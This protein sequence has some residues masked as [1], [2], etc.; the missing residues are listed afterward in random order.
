V[1]L[2]PEPAGGRCR[3]EGCEREEAQYLISVR[4]VR[5]DGGFEA[6]S[7]RRHV[8]LVA[9]ALAEEQRAWVKK[10]VELSEMGELD[11]RRAA[12]LYEAEALP[13][14]ETG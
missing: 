7:C 5:L 4:L 13:E 2:K 3:F 9:K 12:H 11:D 10:G 14:E 8:A 1:G 6:L